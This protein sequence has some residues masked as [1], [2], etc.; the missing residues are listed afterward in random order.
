MGTRFRPVEVMTDVADI[1]AGDDHLLILKMDG[2]LWGCGNNGSGQLGDG[3][4]EHRTTPVCI[5]P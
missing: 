1:D 3:T 4:T 5:V 2:T